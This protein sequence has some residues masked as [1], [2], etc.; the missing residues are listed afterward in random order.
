MTM[1][2]NTNRRNFLKLSAGIGTGLA[3]GIPKI[4]ARGQTEWESE[5]FF[6]IIK[7]RRS[8][9]KFKST[10]IPK[11]H[12]K[13]I[14]DAARSAPTSGNQQP[15]KF[16]VIQNAAKIDELK[17]ECISQSLSAFKKRKKPDEEELDA[18]RKKV[19]DYFGGLLAAPVH[20]VVLT[21]NK[22]KWPSY[23]EKDGALAAGYLILAT[24]A[25]GYG[26]VF[27]T[28]SISEQI[29]KKVCNIPDRYTRICFIPV[30]VPESWPESPAKKD[31]QEFIVHDSF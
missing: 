23:N 5:D 28:D 19:E 31:L 18:Q 1:Q 14:L 3:F 24:R 22:S 12:I 21:D 4:S 27:I 15:W 9:R 11:E 26:T 7:S 20:V 13:K 30:G 25:L 10:P 29:T 17:Q 6:K 8:I 16:I 2:S